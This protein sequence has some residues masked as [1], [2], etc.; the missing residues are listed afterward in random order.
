LATLFAVSAE[1][2]GDVRWKDAAPALRDLFSRPGHNCKAAAI[3]RFK[4]L[5]C[6]SRI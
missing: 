6:A 5:S 1:Y 3:K 2:D 4:K